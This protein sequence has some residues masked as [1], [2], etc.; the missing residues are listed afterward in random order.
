MG[1][2]LKVM[3][4]CLLLLPQYSSLPPYSALLSQQEHRAPSS[5]KQ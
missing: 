4:E 3:H 2:E 1:K 5:G